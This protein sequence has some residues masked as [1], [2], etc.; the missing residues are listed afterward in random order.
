MFLS[1]LVF[2]APVKTNAQEQ[3]PHLPWLHPAPPAEQ[4]QALHCGTAV[5]HQREW[6]ASSRNGHYSRPSVTGTQW[7]LLV[8]KMS[9]PKGSCES[10]NGQHRAELCSWAGHSAAHPHPALTPP[11]MPELS[12]KSAPSPHLRM[13]PQ[14]A[15]EV[16]SNYNSNEDYSISLLPG[17]NDPSES[18]SGVIL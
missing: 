7:K 1:C 10:M 3:S 13:C 12:T 11:A 18:F 17:W 2:P 6:P 4:N 9:L 15:P 14:L 8:W 5:P 16:T